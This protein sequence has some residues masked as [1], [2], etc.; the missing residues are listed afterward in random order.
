[1]TEQKQSSDWTPIAFSY[2]LQGHLMV[3]TLK[4]VAYVG[5]AWIVGIVIRPAALSFGTL[6]AYVALSALICA[7]PQTFIDR[8]FTIREQQD[9]VTNPL[10][11]V[12]DAFC[13]LIVT[14]I[15]GFVMRNTIAAIITV[16]LVMAVVDL[17]VELAML[18]NDD[19]PVTR[20]NFDEKVEK[21]RQ[22][23]HDIFDED[24]NRIN[25]M[26]QNKIDD[27][28]RKSGVDKLHKH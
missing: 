12:I 4:I 18:H 14:P 13:F 7:I 27:I 21:T 2:M 15:V 3:N 24:I 28:N 9:S 16:S 5:V 11:I 22:I 25:T 1:M 10:S 6:L 19:E 8:L 17:A 23:T 26:Q 20:E